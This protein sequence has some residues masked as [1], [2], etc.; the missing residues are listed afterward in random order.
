MEIKTIVQGARQLSY[1]SFQLRDVQSSLFYDRLANLLERCIK[2]EQKLK[3]T[4]PNLAPATANVT[5]DRDKEVA[6]GAL[7]QNN[8]KEL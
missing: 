2:I 6:Q 8:G 7:L 5:L 4:E 3:K 1:E